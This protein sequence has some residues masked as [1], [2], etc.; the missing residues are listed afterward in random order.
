[1]PDR[2]CESARSIL[3][4]VAKVGPGAQDH[5]PSHAMLVATSPRPYVVS[6]NSI[7]HGLTA[8]VVAALPT[9]GCQ[10]TQAAGQR[11]LLATDQ[12]GDSQHIQGL[13]IQVASETQMQAGSASTRCSAPHT[14]QP[15]CRTLLGWCQACA[16]CLYPCLP[17]C[18]LPSPPRSLA[19]S[20]YQ[21]SKTDRD[22]TAGV[23][24]VSVVDGG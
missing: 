10:A 17:A 13:T 21:F 23:V 2:P 9:A 3:A 12:T 20:L 11:V 19:P 1:M 6:A 5:E 16:S 22:R 4:R 24:S 15:W 7:S 18:L 8:S 14:D